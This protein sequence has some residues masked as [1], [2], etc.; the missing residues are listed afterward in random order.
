[1][2]VKIVDHKGKAWYINAM[3]V[4]SVEPKGDAQSAIAISGWSM[5][6]K[7]DMT[8]DA[9]ADLLNAGMPMGMEPLLADLEAQQQAQAASAAM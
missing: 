4:K 2:L 5:K 7:V 9:V 3:Y 8:P 6:M 1:M